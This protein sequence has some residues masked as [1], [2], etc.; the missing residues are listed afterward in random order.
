MGRHILLTGSRTTDDPG[1]GEGRSYSGYVDLSDR[2]QA[3]AFLTGITPQ[4]APGLVM[5]D[6]L[7]ICS[8][9]TGQA[10]NDPYTGGGVA[11]VTALENAT[12][13]PLFYQAYGALTASQFTLTAT[14]GDGAAVV[15][16]APE[17]L[18][19]S[20]GGWAIL[21][22][23]PQSAS[24]WGTYIFRIIRIVTVPANPAVAYSG[25]VYELGVTVSDAQL[26]IWGQQ[27]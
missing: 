4:V 5:G 24:S 26:L 2:L 15:L 14:M 21:A 7:V 11:P 13:S 1:G 3:S 10:T 22:V 18:S 20:D 19:G 16:S 27:L 23:T 12:M 6:Y 17:D 8:D 9:Y 25:D